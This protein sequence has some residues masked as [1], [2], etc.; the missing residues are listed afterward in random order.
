METHL[1]WLAA[2]FILVIA[3]LLTGTFYLVVLGI[4]AFAGALA[5]WFGLG[6]WPQSIVAAAVAVAGMFWVQRHRKTAR[7]RDM[8]PLDVGQS[9]TLDAWVSQEQGV[10]RVK[11]RNA[12]WDAQV[13]G[14]RDFGPGQLLFI[15]A[16]DG[17]TLKV[18]KVQP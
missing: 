12:L 10:A 1:I 8:Q 18:A 5:A 14:E 4:A 15:H 16:V 7:P 9:V 3:E 2:G 6:H 13:S 11:Y 17:N